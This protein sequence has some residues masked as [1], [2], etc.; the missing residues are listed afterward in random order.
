MDIGKAFSYLFEDENWLVKLL[1]GGVLLFIPIANFISLGYAITA[2][3][4]VAEGRERPL[5]EWDDWGGYFMKGLM[6]F[7]GGLIYSLPV[8]VLAGVIFFLTLLGAGAGVREEGALTGFVGFCVFCSQ[9]LIGLY[10]LAL[11]IWFPAPMTFYAIS[12]DF[13]SMFRFG[14]LFNYISSNIGNY[15]IAFVLYL[16]A[17][18]IAGFGTILCV[19]GVVFTTFWACLV[20]AHLYGQVWALAPTKPALV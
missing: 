19:I 4:N 17:S 5:P 1:I 18:F 14:E 20:M 2:L 8:I 9:C 16:V 12:G 7:L 15:L 10:A 6:L 11:A 3:R 13:G